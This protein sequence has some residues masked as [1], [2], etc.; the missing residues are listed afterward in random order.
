MSAQTAS[1]CK[2]APLYINKID[3]HI[4]FTGGFPVSNQNKVF[5]FMITPS[6]SPPLFLVICM[7][8]DSTIEKLELGEKQDPSAILAI[9]SSTFPT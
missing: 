5:N 6:T 3:N 7:Q 9:V 8:N 4:S 1:P 2:I